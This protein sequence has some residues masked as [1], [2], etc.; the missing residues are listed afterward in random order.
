MCAIFLYVLF[1]FR[2][3]C[4]CPCARVRRWQEQTVRL[5][6]EQT[7]CLG[8][9]LYITGRLWPFRCIRI[10]RVVLP[11]N[12]FVSGVIADARRVASAS[13]AR[14]AGVSQARRRLSC[15]LC[16]YIY[17]ILECPIL[18]GGKTHLL[19]GGYL[20]LR[21]TQRF[22]YFSHFGPWWIFDC[23]SNG[24]MICLLIATGVRCQP[25]ALFSGP[26]NGSMIYLLIAPVAHGKSRHYLIR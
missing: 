8:Q 17:S 26:S 20:L 5:W 22:P 7:A 12:M 9:I 15:K 13:Q 24:S 4:A 25:C 3:N 16:V 23:P 6:Q 11:R 18:R 2:S 10:V 19:L 14:V 21:F 1:S